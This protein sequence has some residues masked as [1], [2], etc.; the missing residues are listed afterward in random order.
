MSVAVGAISG[1]VM[2]HCVFADL[3]LEEHSGGAGPSAQAE[4][5]AEYA[6]FY[7]AANRCKQSALISWSSRRL[8]GNSLR[9]AKK[10]KSVAPFHCST[11]L[12]R[13]V[14]ARAARKGVALPATMIQPR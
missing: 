5:S 12:T 9:L 4:F 7:T 11:M 6:P 2:L 1:F 13:D 10:T 14:A 3:G 8:L